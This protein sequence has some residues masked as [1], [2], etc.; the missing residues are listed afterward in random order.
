MAKDTVEIYEQAAQLYDLMCSGREKEADFY[1]SYLNVGRRFL[2]VACGTGMLSEHLVRRGFIVTGIDNCLDM[3]DIFR[4]RVPQSDCFE[5]DMRDFTLDQEFDLVAVPYNSLCHMTTR[6]EITETL[7][8]LHRHCAPGGRL[9]FSIRNFSPSHHPAEWAGLAIPHY[10]DEETQTITQIHRTIE[11][12]ADVN[13]LNL[14]WNVMDLTRKVLHERHV[15]EINLF[16]TDTILECVADAGFQ[17]EGHYGG[18]DKVPFSLEH[19]SRI[20]VATLG[21]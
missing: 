12:K 9:I 18:Y 14:T 4:R 8:C 3:I 16:D 21:D 7:R 5:C 6:E 17:V 15:I 2:E 19:E 20:I 11:Y 13:K 10:F 1:A